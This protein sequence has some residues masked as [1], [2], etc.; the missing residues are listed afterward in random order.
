MH[1]GRLGPEA[2]TCTCTQAHRCCQGSAMRRRQQQQQQSMRGEHASRAACGG[3]HLPLGRAGRQAAGNALE[4][5]QG[6]QAHQVV[7]G[8]V[9]QPVGA[10]VGGLLGAVQHLW[11][12]EA[13]GWGE[14]SPAEWM[15][16]AGL[17]DTGETMGGRWELV[18]C[19]EVVG[20]GGGAR[21]VHA[22]RLTVPPRS[23]NCH[24]SAATCPAAA[25]TRWHMCRDRRSLWRSNRLRDAYLYSAKVCHSFR[26]LMRAG[27]PPSA[28]RGLAF[29]DCA[30]RDV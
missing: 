23:R 19:A 1:T 4:G 30:N 5:R 16:W 14:L 6:V 27:R 12:G 28:G 13:I 20:L 3:A 24:S 8:V 22:W 18:A 15:E 21:G 2:D 9:A 17:I 26:A 11:R 25:R 29:N 10:G 7:P